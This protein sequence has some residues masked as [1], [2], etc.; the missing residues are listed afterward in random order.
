MR[1]NNVSEPFGAILWRRVRLWL[2][3]PSRP[4]ILAL[5]DWLS[6]IEIRAL[7]GA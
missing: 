2:A 1:S 5:G 3:G 4:S 7:V 6:W